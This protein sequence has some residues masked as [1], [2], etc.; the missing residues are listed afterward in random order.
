MQP[1]EPIDPTD[2]QRAA[3]DMQY[4][5]QMLMEHD[6]TNKGGPNKGARPPSSWAWRRYA[7]RF[8]DWR[9][10]RRAAKGK[11]MLIMRP[12]VPYVLVSSVALMWVPDKYKI[13]ALYTIDAMHEEVK[14]KVHCWYWRRTM[15]SAQY[16]LLMEQMEANVPRTKRVESPNCPL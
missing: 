10:H 16:A 4:E 7:D 3:Q 2:L 13:A 9:N 12:W 1:L 8:Y 5:M 14:L 6:G 15:P 11:Q